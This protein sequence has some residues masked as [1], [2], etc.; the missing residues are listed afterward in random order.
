MVQGAAPIQSLSSTCKSRI[1]D[2]AFSATPLGTGSA[3][4]HPDLTV[5]S[6]TSTTAKPTLL[7][8]SPG[9][10]STKGTH[11]TTSTIGL[12]AGLLLGIA[13]AAGGF[14][15]FLIALVLGVV[16]YLIGAHYDGEVDLGKLLGG[17]R[18]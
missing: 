11:V 10:P 6:D 9:L 12:L 4:I 16:G 1:Q 5:V 13:T 17:R 15:G 7:A 2:Y 8:T 18:G 3:S 14:F